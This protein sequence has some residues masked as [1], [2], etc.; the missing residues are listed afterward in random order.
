MSLNSLPE[1]S[2]RRSKVRLGLFGATRAGKTVFLT[3]LYWLSKKGR[4]PAEVRGVLPADPESASYLGERYAMLEAGQWPRGNVASHRVTLEISLATEIITLSTND[5]RGGDFTAA[6]YSDDPA[7]QE[8]A[9]D[10][11]RQLFAGC[12]AY[13]FL[14]DCSDVN[15]AEHRG[16]RRS[17]RSGP[18]HR[19]RGNRA[20]Y[21]AARFVGFSILAPAGGDRVHQRQTNSLSASMTP[22]ITPNETSGQPG[23]T[24]SQYASSSHRFFAV[25][26]TGP[27]P[28][29]SSAPPS[30][31]NPSENLLEPILWCA[32][33]HAAPFAVSQSRGRGDISDALGLVR[34]GLA[35]HRESPRARRFGGRSASSARRSVAAALSRRPGSGRLPAIRLDQPWRPLPLAQKIVNEAEQRL[36]HAIEGRWIP[37]AT[38]ARSTTIRKVAER[39]DQFADSFPKTENEVRLKSWIHTER[40]RLGQQVARD[41][42]GRRGKR[43]TSIR[44][45]PSRLRPGGLAALEPQVAGGGPA[46]QRPSRP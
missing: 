29:G 1:E 17:C 6:F 18:A 34:L 45:N 10:F 37:R 14:I 28:P 32:R 4:L 40:L 11:I 30:K 27:M 7:H 35:V 42:C 3:T 12:S 33:Q 8:Q 22:K 25:T 43:T 13:V 21:S 20:Q 44:P 41:L 19:S 24:S 38:S 23:T 36:H 9:Q 26:S 39:V 46:A 2:G 31:L 5:F 15:A 16:A